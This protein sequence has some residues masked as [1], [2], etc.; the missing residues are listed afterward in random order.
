MLV[1]LT[2]VALFALAWWLRGAVSVMPE[3]A[4]LALQLAGTALL[5]VGGWLGGTLAYRNQIGVDHRYANAGK[6]REQRASFGPDGAIMGID[7]EGME[8]NQMMLLR[9]DGK[10][11]VL[12]RTE[13]GFVAFDDRCTHRGGSL[14]DGVMMCGTVQCPWHGSQFDVQ[15]G[16]IRAGPAEQPLRTYHVRQPGKEHK[17]K[18]HA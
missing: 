9:V 13:G 1:N 8:V 17:K 5:G 14:A 3:M 11:I 16:A 18:K 15:T 12:G 10:R 2:S 7:V 6:W 4:Q